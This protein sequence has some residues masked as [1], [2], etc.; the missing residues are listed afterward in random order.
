[1]ETFKSMGDASCGGN[2]V[3]L[4]AARKRRD[5][6]ALAYASESWLQ[7]KASFALSRIALTDEDAERAG[8]LLAGVVTYEDMLAEMR[9]TADLQAAE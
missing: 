8:R 9:R 3:S 1:M 2:V 4:D 5:F 7:T 6:I